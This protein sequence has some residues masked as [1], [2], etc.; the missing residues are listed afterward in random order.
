MTVLEGDLYSNLIGDIELL[1]KI[2]VRLHHRVFTT[3]EAYWWYNPTI[4]EI[5][6]TKDLAKPMPFLGNTDYILL[7]R[8]VD[9]FV[10][11][12]DNIVE[13]WSK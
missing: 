9:G 13:R 7:A 12:D 1:M 10:M 11:A 3:G 4:K 5:R 6:P 2:E 8:T